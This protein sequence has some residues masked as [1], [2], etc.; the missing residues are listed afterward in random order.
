MKIIGNQAW[1]IAWVAES[2]KLE[3]A[4]HAARRG[5]RCSRAQTHTAAAEGLK[6][7]RLDARSL[8]TP[9]LSRG[10]PGV[11]RMEGGMLGE[12]LGTVFI[13]FFIRKHSQN[14]AQF[15]LNQ[16]PKL[17]NIGGN[18]WKSGLADR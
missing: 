2:P 1:Q 14:I 18:P 8:R 5:E 6:A 15:G 17:V 9:W 4:T 10:Y 16:T 11:S 3:S 12:G 13:S 7:R